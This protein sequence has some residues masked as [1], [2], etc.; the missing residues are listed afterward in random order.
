VSNVVAL[1]EAVKSGDLSA[2]EAD[3][4]LRDTDP[5]QRNKHGLTPLGCAVGGT[6]G[7]W[8]QFSHAA[9]EDWRRCVE[10]IESYGGRE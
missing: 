7:K 1:H 9:L 10:L 5:N 4:P 6:Q 3:A 2:L 8:R